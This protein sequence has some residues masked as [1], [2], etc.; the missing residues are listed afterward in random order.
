MDKIKLNE[1]RIVYQN[2]K[3]ELDEALNKFYEVE[4]WQEKLLD[5]NTTS[6]LTRIDNIRLILTK[7][8]ASMESS[9]EEHTFCLE[10]YFYMTDK[11]IEREYYG[12]LGEG[13]NYEDW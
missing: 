13:N 3:E 12:Y 7:T 6:E 11:E 2:A 10:Y 1:L 9:E 8:L 4:D 5:P